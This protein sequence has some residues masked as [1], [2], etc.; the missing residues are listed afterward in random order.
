M[1]S[2]IKPSN[3]VGLRPDIRFQITAAGTAKALLDGDEVADVETETRL[4]EAV[5]ARLDG[6]MTVGDLVRRA[7]DDGLPNASQVPA[8]IEMMS[9][10]GFLYVA[11]TPGQASVAA[12]F[13]HRTD[14]FR[15]LLDGLAA[16]A[17]VIAAPSRLKVLLERALRESGV[18]RIETVE[19]LTLGSDAAFERAAA[20]S[21]LIIAVC[22]ERSVL[23]MINELAVEQQRLFL[24]VAWN[25][26]RV[27]IG[28]AVI[29]GVTA[30]FHCRSGLG[31]HTGDTAEAGVGGPA[32]LMTVAGL[33]A[34]AAIDLLTADP[35]MTLTRSVLHVD[36]RGRRFDFEPVHRN[37]RCRIC[38]RLERAPEMACIDVG[39]E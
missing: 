13:S 19:L 10:A 3:Y 37:P 4:L 18:G 36:S 38:S 35:E 8:L 27:S 23:D 31:G 16:T 15:E 7:E 2:R 22:S 24:P 6:S 39:E 33:V 28:P 26:F 21:D 1:K 34:S 20:K 17:V 5:M 32:F 14:C 25:G 30:C 9:E 12:A 11:D 29:P